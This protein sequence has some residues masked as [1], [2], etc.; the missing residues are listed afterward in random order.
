MKTL[1]EEIYGTA[2]ALIK[3]DM[4]EF[5][6]RHNVSRLLGATAGYVGYEEGGQLTEAVKRKP[7][8]IIL[9]DEIEKAHPEIQNILL[10]IME[11]GEITDSK[12]RK[13]DFKNTIIIMTSNVGANRLTS[14]A[15]KIGFDLDHKELEQAEKDYNAMQEVIGEE[16][17]DYFAPEF[18]N[19]LDHVIIFRALNHE[20]L[21]KIVKIQIRELE[22]R[23][24]KH[25]IPLQIN[26]TALDFLASE[27]YDPAYG[28]RPVRRKIQELIE[29]YL[30]E[31][32]LEGN[33]KKGNKVI[34][35]KIKADSKLKFSISKVT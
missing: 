19:R 17:K 7:Y 4:S 14:E 34:I 2:D 16:I 13:V 27:S 12:G 24:K 9:F 31:Q 10:Q 35:G 5:M 15:G 32:M 29:N 1:A 23:L 25:K 8:S 28:A 20:D 21:K 26:T 11:D 33:L 3:I 18:L 6:E 30:S 22:K